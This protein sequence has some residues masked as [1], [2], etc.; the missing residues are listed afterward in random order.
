LIL[1]PTY[2]A[3]V[4]QYVALTKA[5][6]IIFEIEDN[7]QKQTYRNRCYIYGANGKQMLNIPIV[8]AKNK[9]R[10][11]TKD[12]KIDYGFDWQK[13]H[14][15]SLEGAY[16]SSPYFEFYEDELLT[17]FDKRHQFLMDL[18]FDT[19]QIINACL[20]LELTYKKTTEF[21]PII[22]RNKDCRYLAD[23]KHIQDYNLKK[24]TQV[25]DDKH[26]YISNLSILDLLFNEGTNTLQYLKNQTFDLL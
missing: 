16:R 24:Y 1:H 2:F 6:A 14:K 8:H 3:P 20:Q 12:I 23:A 26:G 4:I 15:K 9:T 5:D 13:I 17:I 7:F 21:H 11:K 10:Q 19:I 18:N 22:E 25:F